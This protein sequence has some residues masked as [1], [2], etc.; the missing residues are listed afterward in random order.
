M[1][2]FVLDP[3][4]V[5]ELLSEDDEKLESL[6]TLSRRQRDGLWIYVGS[7]DE[8]VDGLSE[9]LVET[10]TDSVSVAK[11]RLADLG[12]RINWLAALAEDGDLIVQPDVSLARTR[13]A[14]QRLGDKG[15]ILTNNTRINSCLDGCI[16]ID[17]YLTRGSQNENI[18][19]IDLEYQQRLIR[20]G[21]E[22]GLFTVL[23]HGRYIGGPE[24]E[25]LESRLATYCDV[26]HAIAVSNGTDAL[27]IALMAAGVGVGDEV[28]TS[29]F[30]FAA[31]GEMILLLGAVPVYVDIDPVSYNLDPA[32]LKDSITART[33]AIIPVSIFG[34]C[35]D[36]DA[37]NIVAEDAGLVVIED[38]AQS[39]G[40]SY[41]GRR[42][43]ALSD[44]A[45]TSFF[46]SKPLGGYGDS[47][48]CFTNDDDFALAIRQIREHGQSGRY[49]HTRLGINGRMSSFQASVLLAKLSLFETEAIKR[50]EIGDRYTSLLIERGAGKQLPIIPPML[51]EGNISVYA[52][53][54]ILIENRD[55]VQ[56]RLGQ[57]GVP[58][59]VHYP[60]P[61][62]HQPA[63][64][65]EQCCVPVSERVSQQVMS[66]PMHPYISVEEQQ[67]VVNKLIDTVNSI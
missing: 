9:R 51:K 34:Q 1:T 20:P 24:I 5:I 63:M 22:A 31:T 40:A 6:A 27:L 13:R 41:K 18:A 46:P 33:K 39:F 19:F 42:S 11:S 12:T 50:A 49:H 56:Q 38:A 48:A 8:I 4:L 37:I 64:K 36:M 3:A 30:T 35:A 65:T 17:D 16:S 53:Y 21:I 62:N 66:L 32:L 58:T 29:P 10:E 26:K 52:Q 28:I 15:Q 14:R 7:A 61:L 23:Q 60:V 55:E 67:T 43:G 44:I 2:N 25:L 59:A 45:C 54:S 47:G 57:V